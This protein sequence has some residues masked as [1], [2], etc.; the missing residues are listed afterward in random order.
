MQ[1]KQVIEFESKQAKIEEAIYQVP[2]I[3]GL[4]NDAIA[5]GVG[6]VAAYLSTSPKVAWVLKEPYDETEDGIGAGGGW[7]IQRDCFMKSGGPWSVRTWQRVIYVM[8]GLRNHLH[9]AGMDYIRDDWS[10]GKVLREIAWI[11]LS[12]M[13]AL[14]KSSNTA[15]REAYEQY[16][17]D[18]IKAQIEL[19]NPDV[20]VFGNTLDLCR[21]SFL[22]EA[23]QSIDKVYRDGVYMIDVY[24]KSGR[25]LL[26]AY[27]PGFISIS[28]LKGGEGHYVDSLIDTVE[29][30][31][32]QSR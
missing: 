9:Y 30:Y 31:Y 7:S 17:K 19:Y 29:K 15:V 32:E 4:S 8:Y 14:T 18:I 22:D 6:D 28:G 16:W 3:N 27:H 26:N 10:M 12:K 23:D 25:L 24:K 1:Q 21:R 20:I 2:V 5:D 13:P 11:N